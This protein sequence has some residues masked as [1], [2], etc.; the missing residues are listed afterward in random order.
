MI[1]TNA[2]KLL[3]ARECLTYLGRLPNQ[4]LRTPP[5]AR[6]HCAEVAISLGNWLLW[7][8]PKIEPTA[9][10][11]Y[12]HFAG[13]PDSVAALGRQFRAVGLDLWNMPDDSPES[14]LV[15][16]VVEEAIAALQ[17]KAAK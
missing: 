5:G 14:A 13:E 8:A 1:E 11:C 9:P 12:F 2:E 4:L 10:P 6:R 3:V 15:R 7:I 17:R 16:S